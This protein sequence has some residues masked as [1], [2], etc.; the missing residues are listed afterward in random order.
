MYLTTSNCRTKSSF[1][2]LLDRK[3]YFIHSDKLVSKQIETKHRNPAQTLYERPLN[4]A[5]HSICRPASL[6]KIF[7]FTIRACQCSQLDFK[8]RAQW[9]SIKERYHNHHPSSLLFGI[10]FLH[11]FFISSLFSTSLFHFFISHQNHLLTHFF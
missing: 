9:D 7:L 2:N 3:D 6:W 1:G 10:S 11:F 5:L 8:L 4:F